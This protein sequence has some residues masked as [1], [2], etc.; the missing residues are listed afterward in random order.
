MNSADA[1][2]RSSVRPSGDLPRLPLQSD[3]IAETNTDGDDTIRSGLPSAHSPTPSSLS[4]GGA[5]AG[6]PRGAPASAHAPI[7]AI[8]ASDSE[9]SSFT[10]WMPMFVSRNQ[11]G[12]APRDHGA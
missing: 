5:S 3:A 6:L 10:F 4:G 11:G 12:I 2:N 7:I 9:M 1:A 8:C